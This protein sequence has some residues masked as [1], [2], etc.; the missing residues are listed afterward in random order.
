MHSDMRLILGLDIL[1][2]PGLKNALY[3]TAEELVVFL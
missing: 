2:V 3:K 1:Y